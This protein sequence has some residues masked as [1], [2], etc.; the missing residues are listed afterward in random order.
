VSRLC[1]V[2]VIVALRP[3]IREGTGEAQR[4]LPHFPVSLGLRARAL[5]MMMM[6]MMLSHHQRE[7]AKKA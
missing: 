2:V 3:G 7:S 4:I 6:M 5:E 1:I